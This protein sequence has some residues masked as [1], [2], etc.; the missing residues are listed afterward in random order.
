MM[1]PAKKDDSWMWKPLPAWLKAALVWGPLGVVFSLVCWACVL[2]FCDMRTELKEWFE[3]QKQ[4]ITKQSESLQKVSAAF[5]TLVTAQ[6]RLEQRHMA[7]QTSVEIAHARA[8]D[9]TMAL[10]QRVEQNQDLI[11]QGNKQSLTNTQLLQEATD[12][13]SGAKERGEKVVELLQII[14]DKESPKNVPAPPTPNDGGA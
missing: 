1:A 7:L 13:M 3:T 8:Y 11:E 4:A 9:I 12:A 5:E 10:A 14:A 2:L 6:T